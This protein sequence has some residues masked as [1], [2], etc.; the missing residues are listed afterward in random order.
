MF[1]FVR[2]RVRSRSGN[3]TLAEVQQD[4]IIIII[5]CYV[6]AAADNQ[7]GCNSCARSRII[8]R[9]IVHTYLYEWHSYGENGLG[10]PQV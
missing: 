1:V 10:T 5:T 4:E 6:I 3:N 9:Y 2:V 7:N 8:R